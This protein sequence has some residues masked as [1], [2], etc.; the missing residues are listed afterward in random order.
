MYIPNSK[1]NDYYLIIP[2]ILYFHE[3]LKNL[4]LAY[5]SFQRLSL[6]LNDTL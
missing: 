5:E 6:G 3:E 4:I 2:H 1:A